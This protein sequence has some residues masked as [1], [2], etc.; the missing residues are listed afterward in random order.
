MILAWLLI[1]FIASGVAKI[2]ML[3]SMLLLSC[4]F[5]IIY[6]FSIGH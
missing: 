3:F 6:V 4:V 2:V 5:V 1:V